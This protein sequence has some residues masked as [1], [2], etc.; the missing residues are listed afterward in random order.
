MIATL[1]NKRISPVVFYYLA[2]KGQKSIRI[3]GGEE[4]VVKDFISVSNFSK[5]QV[6]NGFFDIIIDGKSIIDNESDEKM[7]KALE[8][9]ESYIT[10]DKKK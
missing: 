9:V 3:L 6:E 1:K 4:V 7:K 5:N 10:T 2:D 8:D